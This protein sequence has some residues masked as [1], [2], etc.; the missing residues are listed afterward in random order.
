MSFGV[1]HEKRKEGRN[2]QLSLTAFVEILPCTGDTLPYHTTVLV[3]YAERSPAGLSAA[4]ACALPAS[5]LFD[6]RAN[7]GIIVF[8]AYMYMFQAKLWPELRTATSS[9]FCALELPR[10]V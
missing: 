6:Y 4:T 3:P 9:R 5:I 8:D 1:E 7:D 2:E 10:L